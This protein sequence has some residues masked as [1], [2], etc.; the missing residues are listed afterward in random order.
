MHVQSKFPI[1]KPFYEVRQIRDFK[2]LIDQSEKLYSERPAYKL[3]NKDGVYYEVTY[4]NFR[5]SINY[6][7]N[8]LVN[9]G[10]KRA[11][12]A[13]VGANS[14]NWSVTYLA[15]TCS[16]NV[17][18]PIDKEYLN[19]LINKAEEGSNWKK[20]NIDSVFK[21]GKIQDFRTS[22]T[23]KQVSGRGILSF[24]PLACARAYAPAR[25]IFIKFTNN[26]K[27]IKKIGC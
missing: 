7:A 21:D 24:L 8:S 6:L 25:V 10:Y 5:H 17:I 13:V 20:L 9:D 27:L 2:D 11:H 26:L 15:V 3:R 12:I 14:Y 1:N 18:V 16:D 22:R 23:I 19:D 4:S